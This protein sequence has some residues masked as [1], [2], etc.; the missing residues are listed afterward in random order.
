VT[1][2]GSLREALAEAIA[3]SGK[4]DTLLPTIRNPRSAAA[5]KRRMKAKT[6]R[7]RAKRAVA[8]RQARQLTS[9]LTLSSRIGRITSTN[10]DS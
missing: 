1:D 7:R 6:A 8:A 2:A 5:R 3:A 10:T 4:L 9:E